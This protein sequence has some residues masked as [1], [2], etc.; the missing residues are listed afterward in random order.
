V[1]GGFRDGPAAQAQ[2]NGPT[3]V[4]VARDGTIFVADTLNN[5]IREIRTKMSFRPIHRVNAG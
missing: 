5:C 3:A 1:R 4:S 2:F